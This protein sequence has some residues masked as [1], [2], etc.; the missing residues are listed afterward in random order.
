[1]TRKHRDIRSV[2]RILTP[3]FA[4]SCGGGETPVEE[5][6]ESGGELHGTDLVVGSTMDEIGILVL[7]P[8]GGDATWRPLR[9]V[10]DAPWESGEELPAFDEVHAVGPGSVV[11]RAANG[12]VSRY[13]PGTGMVARLDRIESETATW[14]ESDQGGAFV[15]P[16]SGSIL[17]V[18]PDR[19]W[20]YE[21]AGELEWA[22]AVHEGVAVLV[23]GP[24]LWLVPHGAEEPSAREPASVRMPGLI[25]AWGR[26]LAFVDAEDDRSHDSPVQGSVLWFF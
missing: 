6:S 25:T 26:R 24:E 11:L 12:D 4:V 14:V 15:D 18:L 1:M 13:E 3:L 9:D 21:V 7:D 10:R 23:P 16:A 5:P 22:G 2:L 8:D 19:A 17:T 20:R